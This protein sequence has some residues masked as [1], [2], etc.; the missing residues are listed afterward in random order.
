MNYSS[1]PSAQTVVLY[2]K[3]R[4]IKNIVISPGSR[5]APLTLGFTEDPFFSCFSIV[6]ERSA[7]FFALG[8]AQ[9]LQSPVIA[10]CTSGS[11][12]LNYYPAIAEAFYSDIPLIVISA[13]RPSYKVDIGDGQTIRQVGVFQNHIAYTAS[14]KQDLIH[15][16][17]TIEKLAPQ[18]LSKTKSLE[19]DQFAVQKYNEEELSTLFDIN[20]HQ[21]APVHLNIPFEEPLYNLVE[22]VD[23]SPSNYEVK[24]KEEIPEYPWNSLRK[25]WN[26]SKKIVVIIG[27][28]PPNSIGPQY[29][30]MLSEAPNIIVF[31]EVTSNIHHKNFFPSIDS[32][33]API[34]KKKD[35]DAW[36]KELQP[37]LLVTFG[38]LIVSKKV[39]AFLRNYKPKNHWHVN[40]KKAYNTFFSLSLHLE[41]GVDTFFQ[42]L[43]VA[44]LEI[45]SE[46]FDKWTKIK[47]AYEAKRDLYIKKIPFTDFKAFASICKSIPANYMLQ[48]ANS[49]TVRYAQLFNLDSSINVYCNRGTSGIDGSVSTA[50]GASIYNITPTLLVTGDL[51]FLYDSNGL[52]H[53]YLKKDF[54]IVVINNGGG[55]IFRILPGKVDTPNYEKFFE[56]TQQLELTHIC[57]IYG[58]EYRQADD[59]ISLDK[60]LKSLYLPSSL[61]V[62]LE[63]KTPRRL[64]DKILLAYFDFIS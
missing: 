46:Y 24:Q 12:L 55:G 7:A 23:V 14:L 50:V 40:P 15:A 56:T 60:E 9:Q 17:S 57:S 38:G 5:N 42:Y 34:E 4:G 48:L 61:P 36:F 43:A 63:V 37:D 47:D 45:K 53:D 33:I 13:D 39:K 19:E 27:V 11:A 1:I 64:N 35:R 29:L 62:L 18:L 51:S 49:S 6:D 8:M 3:I 44:E 58:M 22:K 41:M 59:E 52:W 26:S 32:V 28:S 25:I 10:V 30:D 2:C 21:N 20:K 31:T 54:R 16:T